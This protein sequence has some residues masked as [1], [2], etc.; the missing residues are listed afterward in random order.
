M[1]T[2][3][4]GLQRIRKSTCAKDVRTGAVTWGIAIAKD[5]R[6]HYG[7]ASGTKADGHS[8]GCYFCG[9]NKY[10]KP[11]GMVDREFSYCCNPFVNACFAH[12]GGDPVALKLCKAGRSRDFGTRA[13]TSYHRSKDFQY[14]SHPT[15]SKLI[16]GDVM[17]SSGHVKLYIGDKKAVEAGSHDDNRRNSKSW[18]NS[19]HVT[20]CKSVGSYRCYR[21]VGKGGAWMTMPENSDKI[22]IPDDSY[23]GDMIIEDDGRAIVLDKE[24]K[25]LWSSENYQY[26][27][28]K[29]DNDEENF[30]KFTHNLY[31]SISGNFV[32]I[33]DPKSGAVMQ[34]TNSVA[35]LGLASV[36][37]QKDKP[38]RMK[39]APKTLLNSYPTLVEAP[40][41][42]LDFNGVLV[43]GY[44][45]RGDRYPNYINSLTVR[46]INGRINNYSISL[47]YQIRPG[48]DPN[49]I[50][51]LIART[52]YRNPLK[53][54]YG[55]SASGGLYREES[56]VIVDA[57]HNESIADY[58]I[59]YTIQAISSIGVATTG[60][61]S[62]P[63]KTDKPS[64]A[65]Y[66]MLYGNGESSNALLS[67]F[68]GMQNR[69]LVA[70]NN[71]IPTTDA[72]VQL[73]GMSNVSP[74]SYLTYS[75]A[76]MQNAADPKTSYFLTYADDAYNRFGGAYFK[77]TEVN[78][79]NVPT[80][81]ATYSLVVNYPT[82][83]NILS[84]NLN[85]NE[86]WS[87]VFENTNKLETWEYGIDDNGQ[88]TANKINLLYRS[89]DF[90]KS[91]LI[92]SKWWN[93][94][95]E[96]PISAKVTLKGLTAPVMLMTYIDV[97][98]RFYGQQDMTSGLYV[99]TE[100]VD[101]ISGSGCTTELTLLRVSE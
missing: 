97:D 40:T 95:T 101:N 33:D 16:P 3:N 96:Y 60:L 56:A 68:P 38:S 82:D 90:G 81:S 20:S 45:N 88:I 99:V 5:N 86:Y 89:D 83:N 19:I 72:S 22:T 62:Y 46:K 23:S 94:V 67:M 11:K 59:N 64:N 73:S 26:I 69:T 66:D 84:F 34:V 18:N 54:I 58:R 63:A 57:R 42:L 55:D 91:E 21:Y 76:S 28:E 6:F 36:D 51:K 17:C 48:E 70:A 12:G 77:I 79:S 93:E 7:G 27:T 61:T 44:G 24:T 9:T 14:I 50:D 52:G 41:I 13:S 65:I 37:Y 78:K 100:Q 15:I 87:M 32:K 1:A 74:L 71:L 85:T 43:G 75:V 2:K 31:K 49:Y 92:N 47:T 30:T 39:A 8:N 4:V 10:R 35:E 25:R 98:V 29:E 80:S 53:I